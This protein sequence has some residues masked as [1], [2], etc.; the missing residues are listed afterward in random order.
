MDTNLFEQFAPVIRSLSDSE[1]DPGSCSLT[2]KMRLA[3]DGDIEICYV[4]F[5][6]VNPKARIVIVGITPGRTQMINALRE[7]RNQLI[8]GADAITALKAAKRTGA[9]SG[10]MRPNLVDLLDC[11]GLNGWLGLDSCDRLF[12][13]AADLLQST[14]ALQ[15]AVFL[16]DGNYNGTP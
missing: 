7:A 11:V 14:S 3:K 4:P 12:G 6:Y 1:L 9:F 15:N 8:R 2:D 13:S 10:A 5:E 16:R